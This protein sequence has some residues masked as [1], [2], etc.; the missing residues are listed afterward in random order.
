[1]LG[2]FKN[3]WKTDGQETLRTPQEI[4][5][6]FE[7]SYKDITIGHLSLIKGTWK[8]SY[9]EE[10]RNQDSLLPLTDF[11][12]KNKEY[13]ARELWPFFLSR[14]PGLG[15]PKVQEII[16]EQNIDEND[17]ASLLKIFGKRTIANPYKLETGIF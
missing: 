13:E 7:L 15:Q 9:S 4:N 5:S 11:P 8:F 6:I 1:M 16:K 17:E 12:D 3:F 2:K 14:I 10:F